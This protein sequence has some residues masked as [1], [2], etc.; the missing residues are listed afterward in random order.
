MREMLNSKVFVAPSAASLFLSPSKHL[1]GLT[2]YQ[3]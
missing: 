3:S 1:E 2:K